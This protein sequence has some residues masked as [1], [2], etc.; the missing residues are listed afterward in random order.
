MD[1]SANV[2]LGGV[3]SMVSFHIATDDNE[4]KK[5]KALQLYCMIA[6]HVTLVR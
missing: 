5:C 2:L 6:H 4:E 3:A 1:S